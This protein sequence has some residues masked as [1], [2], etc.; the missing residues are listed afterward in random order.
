MSYHSTDILVI[1]SG[2]AGLSFALQVADY[3]QVTIITKNIPSASNTSWA[4]GGIAAALPPQDRVEDHLQDTLRAGDGLCLEESARFITA[5]APD[6]IAKLESWGVCFDRHGQDYAKGQE[7][8]H[9]QRRILHVADKTGQAIESQLLDHAQRHPQIRILP[10]HLAVDLITDR[11]IHKAQGHP[12]GQPSTCLGAYVLN[13]QTG[14]VQTI[15]AKLVCLASGGAGKVYR[16]TSNPDIASG[17]G[18]AMAYRAGATIK[19]LEFVQFHPTC[20]YHPQTTSFLISEALRGEGG[21]LKLMTG[22]R[23]MSRYDSR[24]ELATRDIVARAIDAELKRHGHSHVLLDMTHRPAEFLRERF[25]KVHDKCLELGLDITTSPIPVVPAAHY[26]CGGVETNLEAQT[27]LN[28]L[29]ACGEVACTG[30]HGAN[31]LASNSLL[32]ALVMGSE[33]AQTARRLLP[34]LKTPKTLPEWDDKGTN[35]SDESVVIHHNWAEIRRTMWNY[36]GIVRSD[37]RLERAKARIELLQ[38]EIKE[39]Y[40]N[41][42][43]TP[44]LIELRNLALVADLLIQAAQSRRESRGLHFNIDTPA[45]SS[46]AVDSRLSRWDSPLTSVAQNSR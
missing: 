35:D 8:G 40:W 29:L 14:E 31:R 9:G 39:Y 45:K 1:G 12:L 37:K 3:A 11:T 17:D 20:L 7:G 6:A 33:A 10:Y 13:S 4:Q 23:F 27:S 21:I 36:V 46:K 42:R 5:Q 41:F 30:I 18:I 28:G 25:P 16:Y 32:E 43:I 2:L 15:S 44:D 22:E 24:G 19:N 38:H 26:F 34:Q